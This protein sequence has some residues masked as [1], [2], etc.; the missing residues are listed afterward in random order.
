MIFLRI[1]TVLKI[2]NERDCDDFR[3]KRLKTNRKPESMKH[4]WKFYCYCYDICN[5]TIL[6]KK[7]PN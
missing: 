4:L 2:S 7:K 1:K 6:D 5:N 3:F